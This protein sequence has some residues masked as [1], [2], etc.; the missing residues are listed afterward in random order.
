MLTIREKID[1]IGLAQ[2]KNFS[3]SKDTIKR[4]KSKLQRERR[5]NQQKSDIQTIDRG[6]KN[7]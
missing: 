3:L 1:K 2:I 7:Q 5:Y 4:A 6:S